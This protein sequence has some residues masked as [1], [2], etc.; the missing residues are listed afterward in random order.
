MTW[1]KWAALNGAGA[2]AFGRNLA[3]A[4]DR[5]GVTPP[6]LA[7]MTGTSRSTVYNWRSGT[8]MPSVQA[9]VAVCRALGCTP[10]DLTWG[11]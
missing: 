8:S 5:A 3:A 10:N 2:K 1:S 9:L 4:M 7:R 11:L 6:M